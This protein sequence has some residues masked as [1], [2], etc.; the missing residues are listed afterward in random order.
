MRL[1]NR[2]FD[3]FVVQGSQR[4]EIDNLGSTVTFLPI[5]ER[6]ETNFA[7]DAALFEFFGS[8][9][10]DL[11]TDRMRGQCDVLALTL[12]F[13]LANGKEKVRR[14]SFV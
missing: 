4:S 6:T 12:D 2:C 8:F 5:R 1:F 14:E 10:A 3:D 7:I 13:T 11:H 9:H